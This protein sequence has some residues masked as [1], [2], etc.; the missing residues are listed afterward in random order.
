MKKTRLIKSNFKTRDKIIWLTEG[1]NT[2]L[3]AIKE[4]YDLA[5]MEDVLVYLLNIYDQLHKA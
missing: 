4:T 5:S 3:K 2:Q 1:V